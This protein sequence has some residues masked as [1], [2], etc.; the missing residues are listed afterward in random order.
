MPSLSLEIISP[1][2]IIFKGDC[3]MAVI[4]SVSGEIGV[5]HGHEAVIASLQEGQVIAYDDKQIPIKIVDVKSGFAEMQSLEK[6]L[7]LVD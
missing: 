3:H 6:L 2:G 1:S 7:I 4:P 5:M